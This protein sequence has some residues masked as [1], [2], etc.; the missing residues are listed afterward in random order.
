MQKTCTC[1][2]NLIQPDTQCLICAEKHFSGAYKLHTEA[3]YTAINRHAVIGDLKLCADH[4]DRD[5]PAFADKIR[6]LRHKI[7]YRREKET[8][9]LWEMLSIELDQIVLKYLQLDR[10]GFT[11]E[12][13]S[14]MSSMLLKKLLPQS[15]STPR[16][17]TG[18]IYIFSNVTYPPKNRIKPDP[19]DLLVFINTA[20]SFRYYHDHDRK[21]VFHR[22]PKRCYGDPR[23]CRNI[24]LF[25]DGMNCELI[26][27]TI[28]K[29]ISAE[30]DYDYETE[31]VKCPTTGYYVVQYLRRIF[32]H[33]ELSLVNFGE[34]VK[35]STY[36]FPAHNWHYEHLQL[37]SLPHLN[38]EE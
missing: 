10:H 1:K 24:Y 21:I 12:E 8:D 17:F 27:D 31:K 11:A 9:S 5:Y 7:S 29:E 37:A 6:D 20:K 32:P 19:E 35:N 34:D 14:L 3:H 26:P 22:S 25:P 15:C 30:Y 33:A 18:K 16:D 13:R 23:P 2:S 36:R 4:L 28:R 38:L